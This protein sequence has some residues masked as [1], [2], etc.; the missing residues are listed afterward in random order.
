MS[1]PSID[2]STVL[3]ATGN[4]H[5][6]VE[7]KRLLPGR[8]VL[9]QN[10]VPA[11]T[12]V[13]VEETGSTFEANAKLKAVEISRRC[14]LPVLADD[15]GLCVDALDGQPGHLSARYGG[16]GLSDV[17]RYQKLLEEMTDVPD[18]RRAA[19]YAAV[20]VLALRGEVLRTGVGECHGRL[21]TAPRGD[22]GFGY[23][24]IFFVPEHELAMAELTPE[25]KD[26]VSH[27]A[28]ALAGAIG[29]D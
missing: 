10:D 15:S 9:G 19:H 3:I 5:K 11:V 28:R 23:D 27:R 14:E 13:D 22:G 29:E 24:P 25:Q 12:G 17:E 1:G 4:A 6:L 18:E 21:L 7:F 8:E 2:L 26:S 16:P 20:V